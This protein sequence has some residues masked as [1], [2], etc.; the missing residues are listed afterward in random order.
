MPVPGF[1]RGGYCC[2]IRTLTRFIR[3]LGRSP[4]KILWIL[5]LTAPKSTPSYDD[6]RPGQPDR[7]AT[8]RM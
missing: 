6:D 1:A 2:F 5:R 4:L 8:V 7:A 3:A